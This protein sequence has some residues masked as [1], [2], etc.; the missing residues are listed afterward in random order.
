MKISKAE[1]KKLQS[2]KIIREYGVA[3][4][5]KYKEKLKK[6]IKVFEKAIQKE[7]TEMKRVQG[8]IDSL[9]KDIKE[10]DEL[11]P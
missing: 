11:N 8:M 9:K 1:K 7:K 5:E 2:T 4:L 10:I 3:D 6:N